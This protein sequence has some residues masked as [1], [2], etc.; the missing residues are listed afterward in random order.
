[1]WSGTCGS[2]NRHTITLTPSTVNKTRI[3]SM[4]QGYSS[5]LSN[6]Q[7]QGWTINYL[8]SSEN[9]HPKFTCR[10][11]RE[12][13]TESLLGSKCS[14]CTFQNTWKLQVISLWQ[15]KP[16]QLFPE[17]WRKVCSRFWNQLPRNFGEIPDLWKLL[18][19]LPRT[20]T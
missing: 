5:K 11:S 20:T 9:S 14:F 16:Q 2:R 3:S 19:R 13:R 17:A 7:L 8:M 4:Y 6:F 10:E 18:L 15:L 1:M 12:G